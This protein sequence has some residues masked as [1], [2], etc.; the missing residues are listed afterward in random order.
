MHEVVGA[1]TRIVGL[2][3]GVLHEPH[4]GLLQVA[5]RVGEGRDIGLHLLARIFLGEGGHLVEEGH[6]R[7]AAVLR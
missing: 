1:R 7:A 4:R 3:D 5:E 6:Q 2:A